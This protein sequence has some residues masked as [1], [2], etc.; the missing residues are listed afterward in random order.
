M[1]SKPKR[2]SMIGGNV[3]LS[4]AITEAEPMEVDENELIMSDDEEGKPAFR[5]VNCK[6]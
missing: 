2:Q 3:M 6:L 4:P 5:I 1:S